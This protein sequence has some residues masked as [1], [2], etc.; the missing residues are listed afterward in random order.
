MSAKKNQYSTIRVE[1]K[2]KSKNRFYLKELYAALLK[3]QT[4]IAF[5]AG[6]FLLFQ[7]DGF[8]N[9]VSGAV[10][11]NH[12]DRL[13]L[14]LLLLSF[15]VGM[16][17]IQSMYLALRDYDYLDVGVWGI[18]VF[19]CVT[20][21]IGG[22][23]LFFF[24]GVQPEI[25]LILYMILALFGVANFFYLWRYK[26][27]RNSDLY[28][29]PVEM[30]IQ[31]VNTL[32]FFFVVVAL[33]FAEQN[34]IRGRDS[35]MFSW[36]AVALACVPL[37]FNMVHSHQLT[38]MPKF[39]FRNDVDSPDE[40]VTQFKRD[41]WR[42]SS[43]L[44]DEEIK[45]MVAK[46]AVDS[47]RSIKTV[48]AK[49]G[50]V[51]KIVDQLV[52]QFRYV[53]VY[54]FASETDA[55]LKKCLRELLLVV[56]GL[57][58]NGYMRFLILMDKKEAVGFVRLDTSDGNVIYRALEK[59]I[60]PFRLARILGVGSLYGVYRR[61]REVARCQPEPE[62]GEVRVTY[63]VVFPA[64]ARSGYGGGALDL[65]IRALRSDTN[66]IEADKLTLFVRDTND[67]AKRLFERVGFKPLETPDS[68]DPLA[69]DESIGISIMMEYSLT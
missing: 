50:D 23:G 30:R 8:L 27:P 20:A 34:V 60:L 53:F 9:R 39:F 51:D 26:V 3:P 56:G 22:L 61:A 35:V 16:R 15:C 7:R 64:Y 36:V 6:Y 55:Q 42:T 10:A 59:L 1:P 57:G 17:V 49:L 47:F 25:I 69:N 2:R 63:L 4:V 41:F 48:R 29:Y 45:A 31:A 68:I 33:V 38:L 67:K 21:F 28:D 44:S 58:A 52:A 14:A 11:G 40:R 12:I 37:V 18:I 46:E 24:D 54:I 19:L 65:L 62:I 13:Y 43:G 32:V 5:I 66:D